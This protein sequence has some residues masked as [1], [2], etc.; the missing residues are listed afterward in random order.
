MPMLSKAYGAVN[1]RGKEL[2]V[3][4]VSLDRSKDKFTAFKNQMPWPALEFQGRKRAEL[5]QV[6][7]VSIYVY[8][9]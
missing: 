4:Y 9:V 1:K 2:E 8:N 7:F 5:E 6:R 3:F